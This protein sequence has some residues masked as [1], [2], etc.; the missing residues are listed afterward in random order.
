VKKNL[1]SPDFGKSPTYVE[2]FAGCGGLSL[3]LHE[4]GWKGVF[5]LEK[6]P[7]AFETLKR[8][9][10]DRNSAYSGFFSWPEWIGKSN[11]LVQELLKE[12]LKG[13]LLKLR[14]KI[15]MVAGGPPCQ[16]FS[17]GGKRDGNDLR[18][19]L[20]YSMLEVVSLLQPTLVLIENVEGITRKFISKPSRHKMSVA[21]DVVTQLNKMGYITKCVIIDSSDFGV[22]QSRK[23]ALIMGISREIPQAAHLA[24]NFLSILHNAAR[25]IKIDIGLSLDKPVTVLDA[26][27]D[28]AGSEKVACPD[29]P[30]FETL[31][32]LKATSAYARSMRRGLKSGHIPNS[33]RL[34]K[35]GPEIKKLYLSAHSTQPPGRLTKT[36]LLSKGTKKDKKELLNKDEP[37]S[38]ITTHPDE[39]IHY[40]DAR[41]ITVREM[42][43]LQSFPDD[44]LFYGRY[45]IN[46]PRRQHDVARCSQVGNAVP[47]LVARAIGKALIGV[48]TAK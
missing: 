4:A 44:F 15:T 27:S 25:D 42:A 34:S 14:G 36:F 43:R 6:D 22:P 47:P 46:G 30:K 18:N 35:H 41:N 39:F 3:G 21:D 16:G 29:S 24:D 37:A 28:L 7:M 12:P 1:S 8:N 11:H 20:V 19:S 5:A 38:T 32:Y 2:L 45:T 17:V 40:R 33:H 9:F 26:L 31:K 13:N 10:L 23:R 48:L